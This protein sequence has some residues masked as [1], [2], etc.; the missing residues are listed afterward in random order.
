MEMA[1]IFWIAVVA[2]PSLGWAASDAFSRWLKF[3]EKMLGEA[4][5]QAATEAARHVATIERLEQRVQVLER[6]ATDSGTRTAAEIER[7]RNAPLN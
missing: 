6:I 5:R 3:K 4:A 1:A 7:L 2:V